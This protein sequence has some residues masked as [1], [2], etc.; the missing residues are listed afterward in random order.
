MNRWKFIRPIAII[1][2]VAISIAVVARLAFFCFK[3]MTVHIF[4]Q[5]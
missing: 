3:M 4:L 1:I 5:R 2:A